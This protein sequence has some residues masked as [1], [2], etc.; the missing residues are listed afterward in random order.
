MLAESARLFWWSRVLCGGEAPT[1]HPAGYAPGPPPR[2]GSTGASRTPPGLADQSVPNPP[3]SRALSAS[4]TLA[5]FRLD[6]SRG[7][8]RQ[9]RANQSVADPSQ[10][11]PPMSFRSVA[12]LIALV[13]GLL[14]LCGRPIE[15][16]AG[17]LP[18]G[19]LLGRPRAWRPIKFPSGGDGLSGWA[20]PVDHLSASPARDARRLSPRSGSS[21]FERVPRNR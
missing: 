11:R 18:G 16:P 20:S 15:F 21:G 1:P 3:S 12:Q 4:E 19:F 6:R 14:V 5:L 2:F 9:V 7:P 8:R 10:V 13:L 17:G